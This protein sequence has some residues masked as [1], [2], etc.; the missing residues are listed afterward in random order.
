MTSPTAGGRNGCCH[1]GKLFDFVICHHIYVNVNLVNIYRI[2][3][4]RLQNYMIGASLYTMPSLMP[5]YI[6]K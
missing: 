5:V 1:N 6:L 2:S 3:C 4:S